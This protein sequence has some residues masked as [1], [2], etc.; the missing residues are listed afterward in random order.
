MAGLGLPGMR[1]YVAGEDFQK[2]VGGLEIYLTAADITAPGRMKA[3]LL[4]MMGPDYQSIFESLAPVEGEPDSFKEAVKRFKSYIAPKK[5]V[6][7]ERMTFHKM[8]M[9]SDEKFEQFVGRLRIQGRKCGFSGQ[10]LETEVR[11]RAIAGCKMNLQEKLLHQ[12]LDKGDNLTLQ[13]VLSLARVWEET[14]RVTQGVHHE[15]REGNTVNVMQK[16]KE[17]KGQ[18]SEEEKP[19]T[20]C[21]FRG[22]S[23]GSP[24]C[25]A[26]GK[27]CAKCGRQGHFARCCRTRMPGQQQTQPQ[28]QG[29]RNRVHAVEDEDVEEGQ[30]SL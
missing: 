3:V 21:I 20:A 22:H 15:G 13:Q 6:I 19:C 2:W 17:R 8:S 28:R 5:N 25:P 16:H 10:T 30:L 23:A 27:K 18:K 4:H 9:T 14:R 1:E 24:R 12:A 29:A 7:A 11:D 26:R